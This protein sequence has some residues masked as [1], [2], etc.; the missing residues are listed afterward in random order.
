METSGYACE[1]V[2]RN[3]SL[4]SSFKSRCKLSGGSASKSLLKTLTRVD[5]IMFHGNC[6]SI[7]VRPLQRCRFQRLVGGSPGSSDIKAWFGQR[8]LDIISTK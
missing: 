6:T 8:H 2:V 3:E 1:G 5:S 4:S 7:T